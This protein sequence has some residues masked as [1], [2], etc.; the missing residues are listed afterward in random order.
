MFIE[1]ACVYPLIGSFR[2]IWPCRRPGQGLVS[3]AC[4]VGC[5]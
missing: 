2:S 1:R 5:T 3:R 4:P